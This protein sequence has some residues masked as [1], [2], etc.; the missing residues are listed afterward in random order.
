M[1]V[2]FQNKHSGGERI[3]KGTAWV[4]RKTLD[5]GFVVCFAQFDKPNEILFDKD[6]WF[7]GAE[8]K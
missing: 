3:F 6:Y 5:D 1:I 4:Q 8:V 7:T 2:T